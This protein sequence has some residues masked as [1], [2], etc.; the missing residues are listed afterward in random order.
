MSEECRV[1]ALHHRQLCAQLAARTGRSRA[2]AE[3]FL[4][5]LAEVVAWGLQEER[6]VVV[7]GVGSFMPQPGA[8]RTQSVVRLRLDAGLSEGLRAVFAGRGT[9]ATS[10]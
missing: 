2:E 10:N 8:S 3:A 5:A 1:E 6:V 7:R 4:L 9:A